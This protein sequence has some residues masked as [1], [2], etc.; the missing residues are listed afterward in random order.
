MQL[1]KSED[2]IKTQTIKP[3]KKIR[4]T[5][6]ELSGRIDE[7]KEKYRDL[8]EVQQKKVIAVASSLAG[9]IAGLGIAKT[10]KDIKK[11]DKAKK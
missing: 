11:D 9:L 3:G 6:D 10:N 1:S 4:Q 7:L 8:D 5:L 2:N